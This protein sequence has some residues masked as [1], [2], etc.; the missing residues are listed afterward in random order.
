MTSHYTDIQDIYDKIKGFNSTVDVEQEEVDLDLPLYYDLARY[1][2]KL[3]GVEKT[4]FSNSINYKKP[5][6]KNYIYVDDGVQKRTNSIYDILWG[7]KAYFIVFID[8]GILIS[9]TRDMIKKIQILRSILLNENGIDKP[10]R[11]KY[12]DNI[13]RALKKQVEEGPILYITKLPL[14]SLIFDTPSE[15]WNVRHVEHYSAAE[16]NRLKTYFKYNNVEEALINI[17]WY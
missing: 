7:S 11:L 6:E 4:W 5:F 9:M 12:Y 17:D 16:N 13:N 8:Y 1:M 3:L 2:Q 14:S 10:L 15:N